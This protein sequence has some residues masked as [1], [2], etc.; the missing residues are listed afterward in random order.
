ME[1]NPYPFYR[2][3]RQNAP[4]AYTA[5]LNGRY[6][7]ACWADVDSVL[8]DDERFSA[9]LQEPPDPP[10]NL[11]GSL[12][13]VDGVEHTRIR[14][15]MQPACQPRRA[16][17]FAETVVGTAADE[18][19]D[20]FEATGQTELVET[21]FRP[22]STIA[23]RE[24]LGLEG[25]TVDDLRAWL[26]PIIPAYLSG[27]VLPEAHAMVAQLDAALLESVRRLSTPPFARDPSLLATMIRPRNDTPELSE[28]EIL[29]NAKILAA[30]GVHELRDLMAHAVLGLF[31][32]PEQ[33]AEL[34]D[35][36]SLVKPAL[37]EAARWAC[38]VGMVSRIAA[39]ETELAGVPIP[40]GAMVSPLLAS[41]NRDDAR[42][43]DAARFDLHRDEG[44]H[45]A[46]ASGVHFC[47]GAW[48]A[49]SAGTVALQRL[50]DRLPRLRLD[51]T[52]PLLVEGW[53]FRI[54]RRVPAIWS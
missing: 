5:D 9:R 10:P 26:D 39:S 23:M 25:V 3:L 20:G 34:Q 16:S 27:V 18:L 31:S 1:A 53:R 19:I 45:L 32:R 50:V 42:W 47:I 48:L 43:T 29:T 22:V 6:L 49:R 54:V 28:R 17:T 36:P 52:E 41:A 30:G 8:K 33:L 7:V 12:L 51:R 38:P 14:A 15:A 13:F 44:M 21:F 35:D 11:S 4:V 46:F 24:L 37:E 2:W 40:V